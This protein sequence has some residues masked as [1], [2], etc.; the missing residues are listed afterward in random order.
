M[1][2]EKTPTNTIL[3]PTCGTRL[4]ADAARCLVC[5]TELAS[6]E[7]PSKPSKAVQGSRMPAVT[8][9]L[10][11]ALGLFILFLTAGAVFVYLALRQ[12]GQVAAPPT[13][14]ATATITPTASNT[15]TPVTPTATN[16]P[17]PSPTPFTYK[18]KTGDNCSTIAFAFK[19]SI[20]S[21]VLLNDLPADCTTLFIGQELK[22]PQPTSTPTALPSATLSSAESTDAACEKIEY[23]VQENDTLSK[24]AAN[25]AIAQSVLKEYNGRVNDIV[26]SGE[27]LIIPL[28][29]RTAVGGATSTPTVPPP[30]APPNL[31]L[32]ADGAPFTLA[33]EPIT[34]QWATVGTLRENEAYAVTIE[35][36]TA[37][38][39]RQV[40]YV[41]D[42]KY[43]IPSTLRPAGGAPHVFYW[44]VL[45]VRQNGTDAEGNPTWEAAGA[46]S[47]KRSF[48]WM[49]GGA[50]PA[51]T[52]TP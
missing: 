3:C 36:I 35:D 46:S 47:A 42:T 27:K 23:T 52:P 2:R 26:R 11:A 5:G 28:C 21:I 9:S 18:V 15:P 8:L 34:L 24:I 44:W 49:G 31:L 19:I 25:Y 45:P 32:P 39:G 13:A 12:T 22:I 1:T 37:A 7:K 30:Y 43:I 20:Q 4:S 6:A 16:T 29:K 50:A 14:T 51:A 48:T 33:E 17:E 10:P 38:E 40:F 41:T